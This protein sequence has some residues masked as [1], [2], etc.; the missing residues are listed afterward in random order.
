[1]QFD[2]SAMVV[3]VTNKDRYQ[4]QDHWFP[5]E[6]WV[7]NRAVDRVAHFE[8]HESYAGELLEIRDEDTKDIVGIVQVAEIRGLM[9]SDLTPADLAE[10][11]YSSIEALHARH[12]GLGERKLWLFRVIPVRGD[13]PQ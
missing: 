3:A 5:V 11:G 6:V 2:K 7:N 10:L 12:P 13:T 4:L 8:R 1:M 9:T